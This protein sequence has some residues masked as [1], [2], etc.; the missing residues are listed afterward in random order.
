MGQG[1]RGMA[2]RAEQIELDRGGFATKVS[3]L[4]VPAY[5]VDQDPLETGSR[6]GAR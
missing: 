2:R 1:L 4:D 5:K 6:V 3:K